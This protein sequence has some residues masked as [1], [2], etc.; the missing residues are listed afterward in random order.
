MLRVHIRSSTCI[1]FTGVQKRCEILKESENW[2]HFIFFNFFFVSDI[3]LF[4]GFSYPFF[5]L[6][7][8]STVINVPAGYAGKDQT[9]VPLDSPYGLGFYGVAC[10]E[11]KL[12]EM[13]YAFEHAT[14]VRKAP[15]YKGTLPD[16]V[17]SDGLS[18]QANIKVDIT[19]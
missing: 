13:A 3:S 11:G 6:F 16:Y 14:N 5:S 2:D 1:R 19:S 18:V 4:V 8:V 15:A 7:F 12:I 9:D 10:S 17:I